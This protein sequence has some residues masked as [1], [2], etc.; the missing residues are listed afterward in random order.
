MNV[1]FPRLETIFILHP[2]E[3]TASE[4]YIRWFSERDEAEKTIKPNEKLMI[5]KATDVQSI[6]A[7]SRNWIIFQ[8]KDAKGGWLHRTR[9]AARENAKRVKTIG[10]EVSRPFHCALSTA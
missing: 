8:T 4:P 6:P 1:P 10:I 5:A 3:E 7:G 2:T 9:H